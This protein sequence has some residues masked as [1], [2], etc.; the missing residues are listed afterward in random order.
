MYARKERK[1]R[2]KNTALHVYTMARTTGSGYV[3]V[4]ISIIMYHI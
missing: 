2:P 1:Y 3:W 4:H